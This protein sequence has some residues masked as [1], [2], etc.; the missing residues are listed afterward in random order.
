VL[1][2][3]NYF[4][5]ATAYA[6]AVTASQLLPNSTLLTYAGWGHTAFFGGSYCVDAAVT[7]YLTTQVTPPAGTV[8]PPAASPFESVGAAQQQRAEALIELGL[9]MLPAGVRQ[10]LRTRAR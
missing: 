5:P 2:V 7:A 10:A 8:C 6:S 9:P 3:G 4:D 1:V